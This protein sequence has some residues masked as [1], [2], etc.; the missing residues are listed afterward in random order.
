MTSVVGMAPS[1]QPPVQPPHASYEA[2]ASSDSFFD[3]PHHHR[4]RSGSG[5]SSRPQS[6]DGESTTF[7]SALEEFGLPSISSDF[8]L[9]ISFVANNEARGPAT[10]VIP[11]TPPAVDE[12]GPMPDIKLRNQTATA[13]GKRS[14][15]MER[16]RS[17]LGPSTKVAKDS[18][19]ALVE[20]SGTTSKDDTSHPNRSPYGPESFAHF[21]RRS[22][23]SRS[24]RS[25][26]PKDR[27]DLAPEA[28][29]SGREG[30]STRARAS[31]K[32]K[33]SKSPHRLQ[34]I[35]TNEQE[36]GSS[37]QAAPL[38][39]ASLSITRAT[40][41]LSKMKPRQQGSI[42]GR[43]GPDSDHSCASSATSL[44]RTSD[45][46]HTST[47][48]SICSDGNTHTPITDESCNEATPRLRD[49][50]WSS[51]KTLEAEVKSFVS[52]K[53]TATRVARVQ[54]GLL[55]FLRSTRNHP[56][57]KTIYLEDVE[58]RVLVL[59]RWWSSLLEML[60][61]PLP[62]PIAGIDRPILLEAA[63]MLMMRPEWRMA[64][65]YMQPLS[66]RSPLERVRSRSW[67]NV[68]KS[69]ADPSSFSQ[70]QIHAGS[71]EHK[72][73][74]MFVSNLARQMA[75][76]VDK[77]SLRHAPL[78]LVNFSGK[79]CAYAFFF[80]PGVADV[81]VRLWGLTP[82]L[83]R[84]TGTELG[85][86]R[87]DTG[88]SDDIVALFPPTLGVLGWTSPR[89][90]WDTLKKVPKMTMLTKVPWTGPWVTRWKGR[91]TDL[92]FIFCKYF[93]VLSDQFIPA[94]LPL[95]EKARAPA[96]ALVHAQLLSI[97]DSTIHRQTSPDQSSGA[98]PIMDAAHGSDATAV[99]LPLPPTTNLLKSMSENRLVI[100]L[101]DFFSDDAAELSGARHT[102]AET[103]AALIKAASRKTSLYNNAACFA[104]CDFLE[105][106]LM[107][108][109]EFETASTA[110][111]DWPFW[112]DV[113]QKMA[114]SMNTM[115]EVRL[116]SLV[117][118]IWDALA[119][120]SHRKASICL[121]WLLT[122]ESFNTFFNNWCPMVR[123]YYQRLVCWRMC[124]YTGDP[125]DSEMD[126][127]IYH[128]ASARLRQ[129]WAHYLYM[130]K[131]AAESRRIPPSTAPMSP[132]M[133]KKF[134]IIRQEANLPQKGLFMGF[135]TF[136]RGGT[137]TG[138]NGPWPTGSD[139][140]G[141]GTGSGTGTTTGGDSSSRSET[142][143]KRWSLIGKV[144][145]MASSSHTAPS[146]SAASS[147]SSSS[148]AFPHSK[149]LT[150]LTG[151]R[152]ELAEPATLVPASSSSTSLSTFRAKTAPSSETDSLGSS[153]V[154]DEQRYIFK[155]I[156]GW[157]QNPGPARDRYLVRPLLPAATQDWMKVQR[158]PLPLQ[159]RPVPAQ[160]S[161]SS[162]SPSPSQLEASGHRPVD[163]AS[164]PGLRQSRTGGE[165]A[166]EGNASI[167]RT[168]SVE[169]WLRNTPNSN[170]CAFE[171]T[172]ETL[173]LAPTPTTAPAPA[174]TATSTANEDVAAA[175]ATEATSEEQTQAQAQRPASLLPPDHPYREWFPE[176]IEPSGIYAHNA[177]YCGRAL[178]EWAQ[179]VLE[180]NIFTERRHDDGVERLCD[181]EVPFLGVD[182]F[183]KG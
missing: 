166:E 136:A 99:A 20:K 60:Q 80:C 68:S 103:F 29:N 43:D 66:E 27:P 14:S 76:V 168:A 106:V 55:P 107:I 181:V 127:E 117:F 174:S 119:K 71:T 3:L 140:D 163:D 48:R 50:L 113:C 125:T 177:T 137:A 25:P 46:V 179:V 160:L 5:A 24:S 9:D 44:N 52:A 105:E 62:Q 115:T 173:T 182:G 81:L 126:L 109:H 26:S 47:S 131:T 87:K 120:D 108:Y 18:W 104:L 32:T 91:D 169:E 35:T 175:D 101:K 39:P 58:R 143:K 65:S 149:S 10:Q 162:S 134:M 141:A 49:P 89:S 165:G 147:S 94:G 36:E 82:E 8:E 132:A 70:S 17:W 183:R 152:R 176:P 38:K 88:E 98:P 69:A 155:F 45:G 128:V 161:D 96:F 40:S 172:A 95:S 111:I 148:D 16:P 135:D 90:V 37:R 64:I 85:L 102:Y 158:A 159:V 178:A 31:S 53:Q 63:T 73:R 84:R 61:G 12:L 92:F 2:S 15:L 170:A 42:F 157:Q 6:P 41:Y 83:I 151:L 121:E 164:Q 72:I 133:G 167:S 144:L 146:S 78:S 118:T 110:Y 59:D 51:F 11:P 156:L 77:M 21:A 67:T 139:T 4:R 123:A 171:D 75:H 122:E 114:S 54:S 129:N 79:T 34:V 130:K 112:I 86:P 154:F 33:S 74:T 97:I 124:R 30:M 93:H 150:D 116:L 19:N 28:G 56:S 7:P 22:W 100:L 138:T 153:P 23:M 57:N 142:N 1:S 145:S 180:C 13:R